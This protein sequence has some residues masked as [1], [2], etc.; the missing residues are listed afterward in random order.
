MKLIK[1]PEPITV[2]N[3]PTAKG[4]VPSQEFKFTGFLIDHLDAF[5]GIKTKAQVR[6]ASKIADKIEAA[7]G[8]LTLEPDEYKILG[9]CLAEKKYPTY[10]ARK[11]V[12]FYDAFDGAEEV[13]K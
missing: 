3:I 12:P 2:E 10:I 9:D 8:T 5:E 13:V 6:Q 4:I 11:L 1:V 7:N